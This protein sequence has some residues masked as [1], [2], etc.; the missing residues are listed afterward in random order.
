M[1]V[2]QMKERDHDVINRSMQEDTELALHEKEPSVGEKIQV[3]NILVFASRQK[4]YKMY[5]GS[6]L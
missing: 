5:D 6:T 1:T 2:F 3:I 4:V